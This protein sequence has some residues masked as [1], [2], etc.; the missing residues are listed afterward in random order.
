MVLE[1][2]QQMTSHLTGQAAPVHPLDPLSSDEIA[3]AVAI[4]R[5]EYNDLFF[6]AVTL[7]EPRKQDMMRW[8]ASPET[9]ARPHR[10][11]DVVA[12]GRGSKVY[13]GLIDLDEGK[14]VKWELT[15]GVQPLITMEDL[16]VVESVVRKDTKV[17]E[18]C[19]LIGIPPED[20]HKVYC[21][22][23]TIGYDERFGSGVR[24]QQALMYYR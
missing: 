9:Q 15:E 4:V 5:K 11:A 18:Q 20:M 3:A 6:N 2:L 23:W 24:L 1:R 22:P 10:V 12:I 16:Q 13:D 21:D 14:I 19:G 8:L 7:W 17:I